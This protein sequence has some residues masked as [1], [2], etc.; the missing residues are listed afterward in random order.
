MCFSV[1]AAADHVFSYEQKP[2]PRIGPYLATQTTDTI[3]ST[4]GTG[5]LDIFVED[6]LV[7]VTA[8]QTLKLA[9]R[10]FAHRVL[11]QPR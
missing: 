1:R 3:A 6:G 5:P 11:L 7:F 10:L 2:S 9:L 4:A 8:A